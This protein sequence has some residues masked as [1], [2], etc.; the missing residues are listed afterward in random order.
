MKISNIPIN[1]GI[2]NDSQFGIALNPK[3]YPIKA[4]INGIIIIAS[5]IAISFVTLDFLK[6]EIRGKVIIDLDILM[7]P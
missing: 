6:K 5:K 4:V 3:Q 2:A 7:C 1:I